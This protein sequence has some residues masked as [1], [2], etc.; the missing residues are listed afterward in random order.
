VVAGLVACIVGLALWPGLIL[1]RA[2]DSI[3]GQL[4]SSPQAPT[5]VAER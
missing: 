2:D 3:H 4:A 5:Q 1:H